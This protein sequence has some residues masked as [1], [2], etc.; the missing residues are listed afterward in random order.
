MIGKNFSSARFHWSAMFLAIL[1]A[2]PAIAQ[3]RLDPVAMG[4]ARASVASARG[5]GAISSNPGAVDFPATHRTTLEHDLT[6][7]LYNFGGT[8]GSTYFSSSDFQKIFGNEGGWPNQEERRQLTDLLQDEHLF[9]NGANN[10]IVARYHTRDA[11]TFG[12]HYGHRAYARLN[13][14]EDF[15][16]VVASGE[17]LSERYRFI[18]RGIG[19]TWFTEFGLT[20]GK[21]FGS[22]NV[23]WFPN[24]GLGATLKILQGVAQFDLHDNSFL[25][26][27][28]MTVNSVRS[29]VIQGGYIIRSAQAEGFDPAN[30]FSEFLTG[31]FPGTSGA[32]LGGDVG[33]SG[34]L[35]RMSNPN[36]STVPVDAVLF[37]MALQNV[38]SITW[39]DKA[40]ERVQFVNDT[41][42]NAALSDEQF[43]K[44]QGT[45]R[46]IPEYTTKLPS[47]FRAGLSVNVGAYTE[48][49]GQ[50]MVD[51]EGELPLNNVPGNPVDPRLSI[52]ADWGFDPTF[53]LRAGVS[54]GGTSGF[55][56][57]LGVGWRPLDWLTIDV[58]S[59][60]LDAI[61]VGDQIDFAFRVSAGI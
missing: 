44:Y 5:L 57:G 11:G 1:L 45:L 47:I 13:F 46:T 54:G 10:L 14:P 32:G 12:F 2:S 33:V 29:F 22:G 30:A 39:S 6:F 40:Y 23:G 8:I 24:V 60:E 15:T 36:L 49:D 55:G 61:F 37:G 59:G 50:L 18:N 48:V 42:Q 31:L 7:A 58:G 41:L 19:G 4:K 56:V 38:G 16:R 9:A 28:Q 53:S 35:Y 52:G 21:S 34:V 17:L 3:D 51:I 27:D 43:R 20:Y 26:I 25:A